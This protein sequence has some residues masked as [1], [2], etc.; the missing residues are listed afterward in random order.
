MKRSGRPPLPPSDDPK[1]NET[2]RKS[3]LANAKYRES[4]KVEKCDL[5][6]ELS[7]L[8]AAQKVI[9]VLVLE[10]LERKRISN[11][12][13]IAVAPRGDTPTVPLAPLVSKE[14]S[15]S[16]TGPL[17][18]KRKTESSRTSVTKVGECF[19]KEKNDVTVE[20]NSSEDE[21]EAGETPSPLSSTLNGASGKGGVAKQGM[22]PDTRSEKRKSNE[23]D[24][25]AEY[26]KLMR[27]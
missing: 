2:R 9:N 5:E 11:A 13:P 7:A 20:D 26:E 16:R 3:R 6:N 19:I 8:K 22:S 1:V 12:P 24:A 27:S 4:K 10:S 23:D 25:M 15:E 21:N 14:T 18:K 17:E